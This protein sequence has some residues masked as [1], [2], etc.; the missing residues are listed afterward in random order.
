MPLTAQ[1][2]DELTELFEVLFER[3]YQSVI[4]DMTQRLAR[5]D[6]S[7]ATAYQAWRMR[8]SSLDRKSVV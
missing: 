1:Q 5:I 8:E 4:K 2:L 6:M 7:N 3:F